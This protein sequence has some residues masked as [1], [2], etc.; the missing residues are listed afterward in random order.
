MTIAKCFSNLTNLSL[1][2]YKVGISQVSNQN[3]YTSK[4][5]VCYISDDV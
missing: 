3:W 4:T 1:F 2:A 5:P